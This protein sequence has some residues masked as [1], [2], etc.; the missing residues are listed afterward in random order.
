[1]IQPLIDTLDPAA[2]ANQIS[3]SILEIM[4]SAGVYIA[5]P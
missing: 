1:M 4:L 2:N 5:I 3:C